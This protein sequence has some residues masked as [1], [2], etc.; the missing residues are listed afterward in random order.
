MKKIDRLLIQAHNIYQKNNGL[1]IAFIEKKEDNSWE[2][3]AQIGKG[4]TEIV[5]S[6][7]KTKE[8][9]IK[10]INILTEKYPSKENT[11]I[12]IEEFI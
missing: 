9:A 5:K 6:L 11:L 10:S 12:F 2:A 3:Q 7:H 8:D 1:H 4:K